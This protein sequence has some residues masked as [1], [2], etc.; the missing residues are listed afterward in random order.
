M[1]IVFVSGSLP[2]K[3]IDAEVTARLENIIDS[4][5]DIIVGDAGGVDTSIQ[6]YLHAINYRNVTV[7]CSGDQAR[8]NIGSWETHN[9]YPDHKAGSRAY[10]TAKDV[11]MASLGEYGLMIWDSKSTGTL[12]NVIVLLD[13]KKKSLVFVNKLKEFITISNISDLKQL[14]SHMSEN[15]RLKADRKIGLKKKI[16][17]L[18]HEQSSL[19]LK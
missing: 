19:I 4:G 7:F 18:S 13:Q 14:I 16:D 15:A 17:M 3:I 10:F 1:S 6:E 2:I 9:V 11:V 5:F 8:N 12:S